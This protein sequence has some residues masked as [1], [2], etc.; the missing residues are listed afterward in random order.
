MRN[1]TEQINPIERDVFPYCHHPLYKSSMKCG[2]FLGV[3]A[4][5]V[6]LSQESQDSSA[7]GSK[8]T[9]GVQE[10]RWVARSKRR[11]IQRTLYPPELANGLHDEGVLK[12]RYPI[13]DHL[14]SRS[15]AK[16]HTWRERWGDCLSTASPKNLA[17]LNDTQG[18]VLGLTA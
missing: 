12:D 14:S 2:Q 6:F 13:S 9:F 10:D 11:P 18:R 15:C 5:F 16:E 8:A 7:D 1:R 3:A 17:D 4:S